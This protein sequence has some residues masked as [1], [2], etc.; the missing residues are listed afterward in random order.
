[1]IWS[2]VLLFGICIISHAQ[3]SPALPPTISPE[4]HL[5]QQKSLGNDT[6]QSIIDSLA[7]VVEHLRKLK[8]TGPW[9]LAYSETHQYSIDSYNDSGTL[10]SADRYYVAYDDN[11]SVV[12]QLTKELD[13]ISLEW[14]DSTLMNM[15]YDVDH[16]QMGYISL[17]M[18][19]NSGSWINFMRQVYQYDTNW[20]FDRIISQQW[21]NE[22][23]L[24]L[25]QTLYTFNASNQLSSV[26]SQDWLGEGLGWVNQKRYLY[27]YRQNYQS[28]ATQS[29]IN[30]KWADI[31]LTE[32]Y[33]NDT[34]NPDSILYKTMDNT[35][36]VNVDRTL[37]YY[38][39][40]GRP[41]T[42]FRQIW[43]G[44]EW[45][46][47]T[48][49]IVKRNQKDLTTEELYQQWYEDGYSDSWY[50][51]Y[52][53]RYTYDQYDNNIGQYLEI[54]NGYSWQMAISTT[55]SY[56]LVKPT[57]VPTPVENFK[58]V[59][60][61]FVLNQ[62]YPNPFNPNTIIRYE[63]PNTSDVELTVYDLTGRQVA[64]L[65]NE[66]QAAGIHS[67]RFDA[68]NIASGVYFYRLKTGNFNQVRKMLLLR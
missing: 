57:E 59:P 15:E 65:V 11:G 38:S 53:I 28:T 56:T 9:W 67:V 26:I 62:N 25:R 32:Y 8:S 19:R 16:H 55:N 24:D 29:W 27:N 3:V 20:R 60:Q 31:S 33:L 37:Y 45:E 49:T 43:M 14:V 6:T 36:W 22:K 23:W 34:G 2:G 40:S 13:L 47:F 50:D 51:I 18:D 42:T 63:L 7:T 68:Q 12:Q 44:A 30:N 64:T 58:S 52:H 5:V 46:N 48:R 41:D 61:R 21:F 1:M 10:V 35:E 66:R 4:S 17:Q 39:A 54:P